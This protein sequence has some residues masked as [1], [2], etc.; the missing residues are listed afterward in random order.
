MF[1]LCAHG[2]LTDA[3][4]DKD[5]DWGAVSGV[6]TGGQGGDRVPPSSEK[7]AKNRQKERGK[8]GKNKKKNRKKRQGSFTLHLLTDRAGYTTVCCWF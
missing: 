6:A 8:I 3:G 2:V 1:T 7:F 4:Y 5:A